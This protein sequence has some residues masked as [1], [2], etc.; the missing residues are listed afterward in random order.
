M[1]PAEISRGYD[2]GIVVRRWLG[3]WV[4]YAILIGSLVALRSTVGEETFRMMAIYW[5]AFLGLYFPLLEGLTGRT[6]GKL[7]AGTVVVDEF[8]ARPGVR[9]ATMRTVLRLLEG[10]PVLFG[11]LP[12]GVVVWLSPTRQRVGDL[13]AR[14]FVLKSSDRALLGMDGDAEPVA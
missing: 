13:A 8:G 14:T 7:V 10:N 11:A 5:M 1:S 4:D 2:E 6:P 3:C 9:R 12:A